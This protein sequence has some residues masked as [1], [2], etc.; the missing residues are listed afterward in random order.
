M[1]PGLLL[2]GDPGP[3]AVA[4]ALLRLLGDAPLRER[5]GAAGRRRVLERF[6]WDTMADRVE[7]V[8]AA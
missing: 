2:A 7:H 5:R 4:G 3:D 8:L 1:R 6:T